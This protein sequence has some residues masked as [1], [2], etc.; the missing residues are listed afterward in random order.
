MNSSL[1][2]MNYTG[3]TASDDYMSAND[4]MIKDTKNEA[5]AEAVDENES[6]TTDDMWDLN[7]QILTLLNDVINNGASVSVKV[8]N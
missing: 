3:N 7:N 5:L 1:M 2:S 4:A 6:K 8:K